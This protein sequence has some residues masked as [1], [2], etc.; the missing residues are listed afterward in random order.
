MNNWLPVCL[1]LALSITLCGQ[2]EHRDTLN[3][4][5]TI[6]SEHL[7]G[8]LHG[9]YASWYPDGRPRASGSFAF[10]HRVGRWIVYG[11]NDRERVV[12]E[13]TGPYRFRRIT[14][15]PASN[16]LTRLLSV[17]D[18]EP[19]GPTDGDQPRELAMVQEASIHWQQRQFRFISHG[20]PLLTDNQ[21]LLDALATLV[22]SDSI[23]LYDDVDFVSVRDTQRSLPTGATFVGLLIYEIPFLDFNR[24]VLERRPIG[25]STLYLD[26]ATAEV[27]VRDR[28]YY[29]ALRPLFH[30]I[31]PENISLPGY[32]RSLDDVLSYGTYG[33]LDYYLPERGHKSRKERAE[34]LVNY[35]SI[36]NSHS[37]LMELEHDFWLGINRFST[38]D[39]NF[40][41]WP[42]AG[43]E[44]QY[45]PQN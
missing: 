15:R 7:N 32:A 31:K 22:Q 18:T 26:P 29:P 36:S 34:A 4:G 10:N 30:R 13:Y 5:I 2:R 9:S 17:Q 42:R 37:L 38:A 21:S 6:R 25:L 20:N 11:A 44:P 27:V 40:E 41:F 43:V 28:Y 23:Q 3:N 35:V 8:M 12:R 14:P 45:R 19:T 16:Q 39:V 1:L 24:Q 33:A